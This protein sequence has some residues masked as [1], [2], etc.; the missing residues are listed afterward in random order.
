MTNNLFFSNQF[1]SI[2]ESQIAENINKN[3]FFSY[4][5]AVDP[6]IIDKAYKVFLTNKYDYVSNIIRPS[7]PKG[8]SCEIF[9]FK[10]TSYKELPIRIAEFG[11][12]YRYEKSGECGWMTRVRSFTQDDAHI[13]CIIPRVKSEVL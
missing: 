3:S 7:Y 10:P 5:K 8:M 6:K 12:V 9:N 11:T 13:F 1:D 4:E 2:P